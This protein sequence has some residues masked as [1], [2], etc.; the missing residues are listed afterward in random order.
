MSWR[1]EAR[2][3][4]RIHQIADAW[5]ARNPKAEALR[6]SLVSI[7]YETLSSLSL[8][9][10]DRLGHM[11][12]RAGDRVLIIGENCVAACVIMLAVSRLDA[13]FSFVN[14]RL[15]PREIDGFIEHA[16]PRLALYTC[17]VSESALD[18]AI[19]HK[20]APLAFAALGDIYAGLPDNASAPEPVSPDPAAQVAA[21]VYTSGT[22]GSPKGVMLTHANVLFIANQACTSRRMQ[23]GDVLY[24]ALPMAHVVGLVTQFLGAILGGATVVLEPRFSARQ[25]L[26]VIANE[27]I[28]L[29]VG[30]PAMFARLLEQAQTQGPPLRC[31]ALRFIGTSGS[32]LTPKLKKEIEAMF[33]L[34]LNNGYGLSETA[35]TVAQTRIDQPRQDCSVGFPIPGIEISIV[36]TGGKPVKKGDVGVLRVRGP[37][38]MKG[39]YRSEALTREV[40]S[41]DGWFSTGDLVRQDDDGALHIAGRSKELI[42]RSGFNVY[43]LE[44]EQVIN[45]HPAVIHCAVVGRTMEHNEEVVAFIELNRPVQPDDQAD[46]RSYLRERLSPYKL[47]TE[48]RFLFPLPTA[49]TGKILKNVLK[50][51][52]ASPDN[53]QNAAIST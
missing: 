18:H 20:A 32:P 21:M 19:R 41:P 14:A 24:G 28:T 34:P 12:V 2:Q 15:S 9:L 50:Q 23:P 52:A 16:T 36:D 22:S 17:Q 40:L 8:R 3:L 1:P 33:G 6:D 5:A 31:P 7:D 25:A 43:P 39:Y 35:P 49:P 45:S 37:N 48:I 47:P 10:A 27:K 11:G 38:V 26:S 53:G 13:W 44:V 51:L 4:S 29:F 42:I 46:F 30:V